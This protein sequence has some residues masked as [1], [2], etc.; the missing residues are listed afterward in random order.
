MCAWGGGDGVL[1][2]G[3][4]GVLLIHSQTS[5]VAPLTFENGLIISSHALCNYFS[6]LGLRLNHVSKNGPRRPSECP[7]T[8]GRHQMGTLSASLALCVGNSPVNGEFPAQRP[9]TRNFDVFFDHRLNKQLSK[10]SWGWWFEKPSRSLWP[11]Y[12]GWNE[13]SRILISFYHHICV[14]YSYQKKFYIV[15]TTKI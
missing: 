2:G 4:L 3:W 7:W 5:T 1:W 14:S 15:L 10:Q 11:Q 6:M 9:V 13:P 12:N 8:W